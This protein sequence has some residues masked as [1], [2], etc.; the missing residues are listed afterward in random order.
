[1]QA[2]AVRRTPGLWAHGDP[3]RALQTQGRR[4]VRI[5]VQQRAG[6]RGGG[7][8]TAGGGGR[9]EVG[10][11]GEH[12]VVDAGVA[13][14]KLAVAGAVVANEARSAQRLAHALGPLKE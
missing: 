3:R 2:R 8:G 1:M 9:L 6:E 11:E 4:S 12:A 14:E 10:Q 13:P 5:V 7:G